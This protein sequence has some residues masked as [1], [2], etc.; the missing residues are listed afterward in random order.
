M[1]DT[2]SCYALTCGETVDGTVENCPRCGGRMRTSRSIR[3]LGWVLVLAGLFITGLMGT[4]TLHLLPSLVPIHG[5]PTTARFNGT[6][7]QARLIL[8]LFFLL[9]G[10]G[11]AAMLN[12]IIQIATGQRNRI[13]LFLSLGLAALIVIAAYETVRSI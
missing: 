2:S 11:I 10:F 7:D 5:I 9:I 6:P 1:T 12:G 13:A 3:R 8:Q 4:I